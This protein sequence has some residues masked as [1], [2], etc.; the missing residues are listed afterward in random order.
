VKIRHVFVESFPEKLEEATLYVSIK[1]ATTIHKCCCGCGNQVVAPLSPNAWS[2]TFDGETISLY[3]SIGNWSF[4]CQSHYWIRGD[5]VVWLRQWS[6]R[7]IEALRVKEGR[8]RELCHQRR[9]KKDRN[10]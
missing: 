9:T 8:S 6:R 4:P 2:L 10:Q 1:Y 5:Q 7:E 3:P